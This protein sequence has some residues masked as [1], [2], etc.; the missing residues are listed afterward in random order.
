MEKKTALITLSALSHDLRLDVFRRLV[1][2]GPTG[3]IAGEIAAALSVRANT[4]SNN[5]TILS[6]AGLIR[7]VREG[8][9]IRY[10]AEMAQMHT[11]LSFLMEDCCG[12]RPELCEPVLE[13]IT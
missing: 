11:L 9:A 10:F 13:Q 6:H 2:A 12:G 8:R 5:L 1:Q 7:S 4:L 3:M